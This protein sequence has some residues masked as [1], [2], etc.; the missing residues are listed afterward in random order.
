MLSPLRSI[1]VLPC[2]SEKSRWPTT[3]SPSGPL[4]SLVSGAGSVG[5]G[6]VCS[7]PVNWSVMRLPL[8]LSC[9]RCGIA[10]AARACARLELEARA[11][12][13]K[14]CAKRFHL[15]T[16]FAARSVAPT[17][18]AVGG[19]YQGADRCGCHSTTK[20]YQRIRSSSGR[21][22]AWNALDLVGV[23]G[24]VCALRDEG[25]DARLL[26]PHPPKEARR[27]VAQI[28]VTPLS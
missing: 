18:L 3:G 1:N 22:R 27:L 16:S 4:S 17:R 5:I 12:T 15:S 10:H 28:L 20:A 6:S 8:L 26:V 13:G 9:G 25:D 24:V 19:L 23:H 21:A 2:H 11:E 14:P 7:S